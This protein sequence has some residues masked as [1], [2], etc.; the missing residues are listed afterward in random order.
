[1]NAVRRST[2]SRIICVF[3]PHTFTR[4]KSLLNSFSEAFTDADITIIAD[5]YAA[6]ELDNGEIHSR[7]LVNRIKAKGNNAVYLSSFEEIEEFINKEAKD[8]DIVLT[9]GAGNVYK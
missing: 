6:R 7:D 5:I 4:T 3:Q 1:M 9:M 2:K 8:D